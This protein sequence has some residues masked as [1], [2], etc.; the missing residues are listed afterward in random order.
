MSS[1]RPQV[2]T[3]VRGVVSEKLTK[4]CKMDKVYYTNT[5]AEG[6]EKAIIMAR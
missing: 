6:V 3:E 4:L 5:G 1:A 2:Y